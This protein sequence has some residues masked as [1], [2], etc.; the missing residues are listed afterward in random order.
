ME[1]KTHM[2]WLSMTL[3]SVLQIYLS[4]EFVVVL[5]ESGRDL[6]LSRNV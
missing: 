1:K 2:V 5:E 3:D 6:W 4:R